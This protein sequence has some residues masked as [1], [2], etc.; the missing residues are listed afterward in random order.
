MTY[1]QLCVGII[2][3]AAG[4]IVSPGDCNGAMPS[5]EG[6]GGD[7]MLLRAV[8]VFVACTFLRCTWLLVHQSC[9]KWSMGGG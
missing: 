9:S 3:T 5:S 1:V 2:G 4:Q 6:F 8:P 7:E